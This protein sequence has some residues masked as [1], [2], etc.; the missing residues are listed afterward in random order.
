[1]KAAVEQLR[2]ILTE[3]VTGWFQPLRY[4]KYRV[5]PRLGTARVERRLLGRL[6]QRLQPLPTYVQ[7]TH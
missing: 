7:G 3:T 6:H 2:S 4:G 5:A 1:M